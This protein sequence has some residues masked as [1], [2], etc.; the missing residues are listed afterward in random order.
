M[1][2]LDKYNGR[3]LRTL[4]ALTLAASAYGQL[5]DEFNPPRSNC[6]LAS[7]AQTLANQLLDWNQL[8][9]YHAEN[10]ALRA[11]PAPA[12]R[13]VF[14][15][16]SITD[17][18]KLADQFPGKPYVNRGIS[19]QTTAQMLVRIFQDVIDLKPAAMI[20]LAGT[21]DIAR[22]NGLQTLEMIEENMQAMTELAKLHGIKVILCSVMPISDYVP[23]RNQTRSR[24][25]GDILKLNAWIKDY[26]A[27]NGLGFAD[28]YSATVDEKGFLKEGFSPDGLHPNDKGYALMVP[29][30]NAAIAQALR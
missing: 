3:M 5:A 6:C 4:L 15:G 29:V 9:R 2:P 26:T 17:G 1:R 20:V 18:W 24:P 13:V 12:G 22:N 8:G 14:M 7:S 27:K 25:P 19:G 30:A 28:Y 23:N 16:D 21:N 10:Q 11:Q